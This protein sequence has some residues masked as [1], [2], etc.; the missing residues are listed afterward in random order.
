MLALRWATDPDSAR[1]NTASAMPVTGTPRSSADLTVQRPVPFCSASSRM[2]STSGLPVLAS[3][4]LSTSAVIST[5]K[6]SRSPLFHSVN[7]S[8]ICGALHAQPVAQQ[9]VGLADELHVGVLDAVV[10][11]LHEMAGT[12]GADV[13]A[14][15]HAVDVCG[16]LLEQRAQRLVG[17]GR[18]A[19]HDRR[20]VERALLAAGDAGA[21]EVQ[22]T[23]ADGLLAADGVGVERVAAVDDDVA[24]LH[25][26]G[27]FVDDGVGGVAGLDHDQHAPRLLQRG[28]EF[29]RSSRC[30]RSCPPNRARPAARRSWRSTGC[31]AP[32]CTRGGRS[33]GRCSS[34]SRPGR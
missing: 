22:T 8:A 13:G 1:A 34:P 29:R 19:G 15:R 30:A 10:H 20:A 31:A 5:R 32:R 17:L 28:E 2:T 33:C 3:V 14:A 23:L 11:H 12:V 7:T 18:A 24:F 25:R 9:L 26:V 27:E 4:C 16:D 21:D 6:L